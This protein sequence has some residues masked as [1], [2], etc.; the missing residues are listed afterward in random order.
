MVDPATIDAKRPVPVAD[1]ASLATT[2]ADLAAGFASIIG[3]ILNAPAL[4]QAQ[5]P[6]LS[7]APVPVAV[8]PIAAPVRPPVPP[9]RDGA[10]S[11]SGL[12]IAGDVFPGQLQGQRC[13][14]PMQMRDAFGV[15]R[16]GFCGQACAPGRAQCS[17]H[18]PVADAAARR[19]MVVR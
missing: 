16:P 13:S 2:I 12:W 8:S 14:H 19:I 1:E 3:P 10:S 15:T 17:T 6:E 5:D 9:R 4:R 18:A 7:A 11:G